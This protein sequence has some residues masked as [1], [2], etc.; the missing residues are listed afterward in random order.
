MSTKQRCVTC[1]DSSNCKAQCVKCLDVFCDFQPKCGFSYDQTQYNNCRACEYKC[2]SR[3][4][5][6]FCLWLSF[7]PFIGIVQKMYSGQTYL[8]ETQ[9]DMGFLCVLFLASFVLGMTGILLIQKRMTL[10]EY[11][12]AA[13]TL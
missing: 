2:K 13:A 9:D 3:P 4:Y 12:Q 7:L 10:A 1:G 6:L 8:L 5:G 11:A